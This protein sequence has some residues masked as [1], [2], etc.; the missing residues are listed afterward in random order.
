MSGPSGPERITMPVQVMYFDTDA[1]GVV[2][3]LAYL[4]IIET[5][6]T[7]L[8]IQLGMDFE[9]IERTRTHP[10]VVRTEIDYR[11]PARLGEHLLVQGR[12]A[13]VAKA[14]FWVEFEIE[15]THTQDVIVTC[16]QALALVRLPE[17]RPVRIAAGFPGLAAAARQ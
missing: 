17:G 5:A 14:R 12:L 2:S 10:V 4:R 11:K 9:T 7:L 6:R 1:G 13:E 3:N 8:G 15:R 16:R